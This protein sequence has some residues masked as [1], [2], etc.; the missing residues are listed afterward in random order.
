MKARVAA[1][2][3]WTIVALQV[4]L[5]AL[6]IVFEA[7]GNST[8]SS[9]G[10]GFAAKALGGA[11]AI[12][13]F[14]VVGVVILSRR[15]GHPIGWILCTMNLGWA[16]NHFAG[17]YARYALVANPGSLPAGKLA[18]WLY[19]WPGFVSIGL[20]V[21]LGL[22]FPDGTLL[23][24]RW[25][26]VAWLVAGY[27]VVAPVA[28]AFAPGPIDD[29]IGFAVTNPAGVGGSLGGVLH[30]AAGVVQMLTVPLFAVAAVSLILRQRRARGQERQQLKWFTSSVAV[31]AVLVIVQSAIM[32]GYGSQAE[33]P[34]WAR[35][36]EDVGNVI[37]ALIPA[38]AACIAILKYRLYEIDIIINR[39]LV[40]GSLTA[41]LVLFYFGG[42]VVL[43][44]VF[45]ALTGQKSTL[46]VVASTLAIAALFNPL[47][48]G[49]QGFVDRRFYRR[50]YDAAK[51]LEA[52]NSR[53]R[54]ETDLDALGEDLVEVVRETMQPTHA[55][56]WLRPDHGLRKRGAVREPR[57]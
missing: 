9:L 51:T 36:F 43:Q 23:S 10:V 44:R 24:P 53:L 34:V 50:K 15:P 1:A 55:S 32:V 57:S 16:I 27:I 20:F 41:T 47:R 30:L 49:L 56:L 48:R 22:L 42:I 28:L 14:P 17:S 3:P 25:R 31:V 13:V 26:P 2:L 8:S 40:Y 5:I 29:T 12:L 19:F 21:F 11:A 35:L 38:V 7:L 18:V 6:G 54:E 39:T 4:V 45:V 33:M 37:D 52:F 46:A